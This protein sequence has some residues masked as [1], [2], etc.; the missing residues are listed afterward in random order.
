MKNALLWYITCGSRKN[1]R[2]GGASRLY[3]QGGRIGD[4]GTTL[5]VA[6]YRNTLLRNTEILVT[7]NVPRSPILVTLMTVAIRSSETSVLIRATQRNILER[8]YSSLESPL[9]WRF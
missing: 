8:R 1:R 5:A 4:L 7:A 2:F 3:H 9:A 6:S